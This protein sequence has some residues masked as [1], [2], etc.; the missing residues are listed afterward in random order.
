MII[1]TCTFIRACSNLKIV[2]D[3]LIF[4]RNV[5]Y[6]TCVENINDRAIF[7]FP[8]IKQRTHGITESL[9]AQLYFLNIILK[10]V[11]QNIEVWWSSVIYCGMEDCFSIIV[12]NSSLYTSAIIPMP[13]RTSV[14][15]FCVSNAVSGRIVAIERNKIS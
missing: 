10:E 15:I 2:S 14:Q 12:F 3:S 8:L 1:A 5:T 4:T 13:L 7:L 9:P 6:C 11:R